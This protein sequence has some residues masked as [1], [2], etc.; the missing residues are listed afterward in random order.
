MVRGVGRRAVLA[1]AGLGPAAL[2]AGGAGAAE[3]PE[4]GFAPG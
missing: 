2:A 3:A 1:V 4:Y